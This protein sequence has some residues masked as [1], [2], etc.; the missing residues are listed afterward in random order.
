MDGADGKSRPVADCVLKD[1]G[2][3]LVWAGTPL[4]RRMY[5]VRL[6]AGVADSAKVC[7]D[8]ECIASTNYSTTFLFAGTAAY[9]DLGQGI[10]ADSANQ[11]MPNFWKYLETDDLDGCKGYCDRTVCAGI[12]YVAF[13]TSSGK[14]G[15][16]H[17]HGAQA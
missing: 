13:D 9:E 8:A 11:I 7:N 17:L 3:A 5:E 4:A 12:S 1:Y 15:K 10:C 14:K 2:G 16:C 6:T